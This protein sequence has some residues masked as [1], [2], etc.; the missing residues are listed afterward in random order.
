MAEEF[1]PYYKWLAIAPEDQPPDQYRLL[2]V[3]T[4]EDDLEVIEAAANQRMGHLRTYQ[5]GKHSAQSQKLLNEVA[6]AKIVLL[7]P[8]KKAEYDKELESKDAP[9]LRVA[10]P[11]ADEPEPPDPPPVAVPNFSTPA[12]TSRLSTRR[13]P[14]KK[15]SIVPV[16]FGIAAVALVAVAAFILTQDTDNRKAATRP[17][18]SQPAAE[19]PPKNAQPTDV[20]SEPPVS[21]PDKLPDKLPPLQPLIPPPGQDPLFEPPRQDPLMPPPGPEPE[22]PTTNIWIAAL[23]GNAEVVRQNITAAADVNG[24]ATEGNTPLFLAALHGQTEAARVL[25]EHGA[26]PDI[27]NNDGNTPLHMAAFFAH[28]RFVALLIQK[29]A[30]VNVKNHDG[31]TP[32]DNVAGPWSDG[33]AA[34]YLR[35]AGETGMELNLERIKVA[36]LEAAEL[37]RNA[38]GET[39]R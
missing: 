8:E 1:D 14:G 33:L 6:A 39:G 36:R 30:D 15:P 2:G 32:A 16:L 4:F 23:Q 27:G 34:F 11:L 22:T 19:A 28:P 3:R 13:R 7:N 9:A 38:G 18:P 12:P 31:K 17:R 20:P 24:R 25:L 21:P 10:V 5:S 37:L 29:G 35:I 26:D